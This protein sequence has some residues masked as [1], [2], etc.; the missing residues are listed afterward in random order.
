MTIS[1]NFDELLT[2]PRLTYLTDDRLDIV[3]AD[4]SDVLKY[5]RK[6]NPNKSSGPDVISNHILKFCA[7]SLYK[8]LTK[9]FNYSLRKGVYP[10]C[11]KI[12]NICPVYK[13]KGEKSEKSNYRTIALLSCMSK[14]LE[15]IIYYSLYE[16]CVSNELLISENSWFKRNDSTVNQLIAIT[17]N[18]YKS[19]DSGKDV[20]ALFLDVSKAFDKVWHE[21]LIFKLRQF[22]I[23]ATLI[24]LLENYLT[25][26]SQRVVL[27]G[28]TS[29]SQYISAQCSILG[30]LLFLIYVN[31]VKHNIL[32]SIKLFADDTALIKEINNPVNDFGELNNNLE[33]L[34]S[35]SKQW[36]ITF[37]ADKKKY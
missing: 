1:N 19:L 21:G 31:D 8:P 35:W 13:N 34:N 36:L 20:C 32:S 25:D 14:I 37:N 10:S 18:I 27:N 3:T 16:Y 28:K 6:A 17:H 15:K 30:P 4:E 23:T 12:S 5:L 9:L 2:L 11:W 22:G 24:S 33:T 29:P 7:D 26:R